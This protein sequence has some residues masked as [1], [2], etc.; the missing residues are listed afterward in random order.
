MTPKEA[1]SPPSKPAVCAR[2][3]GS[4]RRGGPYRH[5]YWQVP[6]FNKCTSPWALRQ[7][8]MGCA[9]TCPQVPPLDP[10]HVSSRLA[11]RKSIWG[12]ALRGESVRPPRVLSITR[13][14]P[15]P[16]PAAPALQKLSFPNRPLERGISSRQGL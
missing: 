2:G 4:V 9:D 1:S 14:S 11:V 15:H 10:K 13:F 5:R 12:A 6:Y 8:P 7:R 16:G 3:G